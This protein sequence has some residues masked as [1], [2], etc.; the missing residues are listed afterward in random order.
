MDKGRMKEKLQKLQKNPGEL[1][2]ARQKALNSLNK[3]LEPEKS[4]AHKSR[5]R[6]YGTLVVRSDDGRSNVDLE[7]GSTGGGTD[8][9]VASRPTL[10]ERWKTLLS[11][12][13]GDRVSLM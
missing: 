5:R 13:G 6:E 9:A 4:A 7:S 10:A 2:T 12:K 3:L 8:L 11:L 1:R